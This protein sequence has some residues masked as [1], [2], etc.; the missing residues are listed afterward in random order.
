ML[1]KSRYTKNT[2]QKLLQTIENKETHTYKHTQVKLKAEQ[3]AGGLGEGEE[4]GSRCHTWM[5]G[6][7]G[8]RD[9]VQAC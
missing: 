9:K 8:L 7:R 6:G 5:G 4:G 1:L 3:G 2:R